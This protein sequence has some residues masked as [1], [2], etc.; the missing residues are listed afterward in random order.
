LF[1]S[2]PSSFFILSI[3]ACCVQQLE[4]AESQAQQAQRQTQKLKVKVVE[5]E[6]QLDAQREEWEKVAMERSV[7]GSDLEILRQTNAKLREQVFEKNT[8]VGE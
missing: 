4:Q 1:L 7:L 5:L 6:S 2:H 3:F 8:S